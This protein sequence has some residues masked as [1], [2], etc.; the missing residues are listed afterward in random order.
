MQSKYSIADAI[1][2]LISKIKDKQAWSIGKNS[3]SSY[4]ASYRML[5][6]GD[7]HFNHTQRFE[8]F[9]FFVVVCLCHRCFFFLPISTKHFRCFSPFFSTRSLVLF[10]LP[11]ILCLREQISLRSRSLL[12]ILMG[13]MH[14]FSWSTV[15]IVFALDFACLQ[16]RV[17]LF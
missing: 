7:D 14:V 15:T 10:C 17:N 4:F 5:F 3:Q 9:R 6:Q 8:V 13:L 1:V 11:F 2:R 16:R 12:H